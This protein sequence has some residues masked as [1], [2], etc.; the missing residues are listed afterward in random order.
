MNVLLLDTSYNKLQFSL[1]QIHPE[2]VVNPLD[3]QAKASFQVNVNYRGVSEPKRH[4]EIAL[5][6]LDQLLQ[7]AQLTLDDI[8]YLAYNRGPGS[9]VGTRIATT[10][11]L[12]LAQVAPQFHKILAL[13]GLEMQA[14][15]LKLVQY[16]QRQQQKSRILGKNNNHLELSDS[17]KVIVAIDANMSEAYA[18]VYQLSNGLRCQPQAHEQLFKLS[19]LAILLKFV[20]ATPVERSELIEQEPHLQELSLTSSDDVILAGNAWLQYLPRLQADALLTNEQV[21]LATELFA[22]Q[23]RTFE[24]AILD[25]ALMMQEQ[26]DLDKLLG[27]KEEQSLLFNTGHTSLQL[28]LLLEYIKEQRFT[29]I[30]NIEV[31][32]IR[33]QVTN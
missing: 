12:A 25:Y 6:V 27:V 22:Q 5:T 33:D 14:N 18:C 31:V 21:V 8:E 23:S 26:G 7:E 24:T 17:S 2:A 28:P 32:Y 16:Q 29:P 20:L 1:Y 9:F 15:H 10:M 11:V 3:D 30:D 4:G 13:S 19:D